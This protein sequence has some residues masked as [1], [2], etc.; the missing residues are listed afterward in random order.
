MKV[1][2]THF[3]TL[4]N[5]F[6]VEKYTLE[7]HRGITVWLSSFGAAITQLAMPDRNGR[8][9]NIVLGYDTVDGYARDRHN[10][11]G[12]VGRYA[13]R[14][15]NGRFYLDGRRYDLAKNDGAHHLHGGVH[16]FNKKLWS[17]EA[18]V[19]SD[20]CS[21]TFSY[22]SEDGEE[23]YPGNLNVTVTYRLTDSNELFIDY[24][25]RTDRTTPVNLTN[26]AYWNLLGAG[27]NTILDHE[28]TLNCSRYLDVDETL[29]PSGKVIA[30]DSSPLDFTRQKRIGADIAATGNGYDHCFVV[31]ETAMP[32][33]GGLLLAARVSEHTH[34][35]CMAVYTDQPGVQ[36][37]TGNFLD[38]VR[39]CRGAV[40]G[41]HAALCLE[42]QNFPDAVNQTSFPDPFL[43]PGEV[44]RTTTRHRFTLC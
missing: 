1:D 9:E 38:E 5:G 36:L 41:K 35:R 34:G 37:Y 43:S 7:N 18:A 25:A 6:Q 20:A 17:A 15:A 39:G 13:N 2:S 44:Y 24:T 29:I 8:I 19:G 22:L 31:D 10:L 4:A 33:A 27:K 21:V 16:G 23:N 30:V 32:N 11:G 28:L 3:G 26:H 42:T 40:Y 12:I 14:I